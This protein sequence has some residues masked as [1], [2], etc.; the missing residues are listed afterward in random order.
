MHD[1]DLRDARRRQR[2][3]VVEDPAEVLAIGKDLVLGGRNA[4]PLST[5]YMH[6]SRFSRAISCARR[7][8]FTVSG[9]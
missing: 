1:R 3:L 2:R 6:G 9:K 4:P 8:F 5:R 7:C